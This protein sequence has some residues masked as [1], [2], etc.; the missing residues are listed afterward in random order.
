MH[1]ED[2]ISIH[3]MRLIW[4]FTTKPT[5]F[6]EI[7]V[8]ARDGALTSQYSEIM[9]RTQEE[10]QDNISLEPEFRSIIYITRGTGNGTELFCIYNIVRN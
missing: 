6:K 1:E 7:Q 4:M 5:V 2:S 8:T 9:K 3:H 10:E